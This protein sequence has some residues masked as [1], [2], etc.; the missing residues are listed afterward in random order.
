[1]LSTPLTASPAVIPKIFPSICGADPTKL[2]G[3]LVTV[4]DEPLFVDGE[5]ASVAVNAFVDVPEIVCAL[6]P[7]P[8]ISITAP[9]SVADNVNAFALATALTKKVVSSV[10]PA[11]AVPPF[12]L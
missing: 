3:G 6:F 8:V 10:K 9:P 5:N 7:V 4:Q 1:M 2:S 11:I 12:A